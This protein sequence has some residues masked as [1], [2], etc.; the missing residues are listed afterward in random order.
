[1]TSLSLFK[2]QIKKHLHHISSLPVLS[3]ASPLQSMPFL[4]PYNE[5]WSWW[6][7]LIIC[8]LSL[9]FFSSYPTFYYLHCVFLFFPDFICRPHQFIGLCFLPAPLIFL[10]CA[11]WINEIKSTCSFSKS[12]DAASTSSLT[13]LL[14]GETISFLLIDPLPELHRI[15]TYGGDFHTAFRSAAQTGSSC[16]ATVSLPCL[17]FHTDRNLHN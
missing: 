12:V 16:V 13:K 8:N 4:H 11:K 3:T 14:Q 9:F 6:W 7:W 5:L 15:A 1:M 17:G 2:Q 10:T